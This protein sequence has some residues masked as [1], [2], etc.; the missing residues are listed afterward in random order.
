MQINLQKTNNLGFSCV[1]FLPHKLQRCLS[2]VGGG[3][4]QQREGGVKDD[5]I[6]PAL[7]I[8]FTIRRK[9]AHRTAYEAGYILS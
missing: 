5:K 6:K 9:E 1:D 7:R 2:H 3:G 4:L 8:S